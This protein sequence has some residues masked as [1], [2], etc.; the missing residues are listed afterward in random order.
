MFHS[1]TILNKVWE[2]ANTVLFN[3]TEST[4]HF[5]LVVITEPTGL[6]LHPFDKSFHPGYQEIAWKSRGDVARMK[7]KQDG[8][9]N[10]E[11]NGSSPTR[12]MK[13]DL[14]MK[15]NNSSAHERFE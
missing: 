15:I 2:H 5:T 3:P 12:L 7:G 4:K 11:T 8:S 9:Q 10:Q 14:K 6:Q 1:H 13:I